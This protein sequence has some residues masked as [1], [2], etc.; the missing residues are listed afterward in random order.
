KNVNVR[1]A[2]Y[3]AIDREL[4]VKQL[5]K[6]QGVPS[7]NFVPPDIPGNNP[8]AA[9]PGGPAEAKKYL[10]DAGYPNGNG[11]PGFK[12]GY[13]PTQNEATLVSQAIV[14]MWKDVLNINV[15]LLP[16]PTD[17]RTRIRTEPYDMYYGGWGPD[18]LDPNRW[19]NLILRGDYVQSLYTG[20]HELSRIQGAHP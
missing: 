5:L 14:T 8:G 16:V 9:L 20:T 10:A 1:K 3:L 19:H 4:I 7:L 18:L 13:V 11:F 17:W 2:L 6:G 15:E 12:L